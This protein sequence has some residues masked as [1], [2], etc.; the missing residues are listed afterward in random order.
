MKKPRHPTRHLLILFLFQLKTMFMLILPAYNFLNRMMSDRLTVTNINLSVLS[1]LIYLYKLSV[2]L[3]IKQFRTEGRKRSCI[4][5]NL[6]SSPA[7]PFK[8]ERG[9]TCT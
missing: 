9:D 1:G 3:L 2:L 8:L 4:I 5:C 6:V 7:P